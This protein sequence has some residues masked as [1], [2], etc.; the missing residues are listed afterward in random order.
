LEA[1]LER[2]LVVELLGLGERANARFVAT[3]SYERVAAHLSYVRQHFEIRPSDADGEALPFLVAVTLEQR[4][5]P[6][7][8]QAPAW[9]I[10]NFERVAA[11]D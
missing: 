1:F 9:R 10:A 6:R 4:G 5:L 3:D 2:P 8:S 11:S 7:D